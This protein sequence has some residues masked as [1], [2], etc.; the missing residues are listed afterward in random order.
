[1]KHSRKRTLSLILALALALA[2]SGCTAKPTT[3]AP[4]ATPAAGGT[5]ASAA[6]QASEPV[7]NTDYKVALCTS[8]PINDNDWNALAFEGLELIKEKHGVETKYVESIRQSDQEEVMRNFITQGF[9]VIYAHGYEFGDTMQK[10]ADEYP[11]VKFIIT[12]AGIVNGTNMASC[13]V[14]NAEQGFLIGAAAALMTKTNHIVLLGSIEMPPITATLEGFTAGAA[15]INPDVV[16][17]TGYLGSFD[18]AAKMKEMMTSFINQGVDVGS[19]VADLAAMG[20]IEALAEAGKMCIGA[21]RDQ[22]IT[23]PDAVVTNIGQSYAIAMDDVFQRILDG[24][25]TGTFYNEGVATGA[26]FLIPNAKYTVP[27]DVQQKLDAVIEE[28]KAGTI[29]SLNA[30]TSGG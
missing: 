6:P 12:S 20:G 28:I 4:P 17:E 5:T 15:H 16:A 11:D 7:A 10:L 26:I 13:N 23:A 30:L 3:S 25:F 24:S 14:V 21:N 22:S 9:N 18:D 19:C 27:E 1:M 29:E 8:G 2:V